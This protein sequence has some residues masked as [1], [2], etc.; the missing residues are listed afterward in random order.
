MGLVRLKNDCQYLELIKDVITY[1]YPCGKY[2]KKPV[3]LELEN[4]MKELANFISDNL[5]YDLDSAFDSNE[6]VLQVAIE[7]IYYSSIL[8]PAWIEK[9][10][11]LSLDEI[12]D[13]MSSFSF[14]NCEVHPTAELVKKYC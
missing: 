11:D 9:F 1:I 12:S 8:Q 6:W 10:R 3:R 13:V 4:K 7:D 5:P 14:D 2:D